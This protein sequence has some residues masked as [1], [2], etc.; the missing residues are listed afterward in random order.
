MNKIDWNNPPH[1]TNV[2]NYR[3]H[4][5]HDP[6]YVKVDN[7]NL[8]INWRCGETYSPTVYLYIY[9]YIYIFYIIYIH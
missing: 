8:R 1:A 2:S 5:E 4:D 9:I 3:V 7:Q 6:L